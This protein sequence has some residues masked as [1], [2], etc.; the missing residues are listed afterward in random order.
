MCRLLKQKAKE[1]KLNNIN[2]LNQMWEDVDL[3]K[4]GLLH[5]FDLVLSSEGWVQEGDKLTAE[6]LNQVMPKLYH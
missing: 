2:V 5:K 6:Y 3:E 1:A 4:V